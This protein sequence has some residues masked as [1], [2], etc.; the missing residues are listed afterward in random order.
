M[1]FQE[2]DL[3]CIRRVREGDPSALEEL[4]D[5]HTP[6][7]YSVALRIVR[8]ATDAEDAVQAAWVQAWKSAASYDASRGAVIAWLLNIVR[9]RALDAYRSLASRRRAE[10]RAEAQVDVGPTPA[11]PA[12]DTTRGDLGQRV[13]TALTQLGPQQR[14]VIEIAYF[15]GLSQSEI[16][17][18]LGAPL[19]TVKSWTRQGLMKLREMLPEEEWV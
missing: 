2:L 13:R 6:L 15:E 3:S 11:D 10:D 19:G 12:A 9:S 14:Q 18:R 8:S 16:A 7:L 1:T 17:E 4:Y 5:R